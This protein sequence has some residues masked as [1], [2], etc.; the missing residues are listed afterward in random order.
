MKVTVLPVDARSTFSA[1]VRASVPEP[2]AALLTATVCVPETV[3]SVPPPVD[4]SWT[5]K[6]PFAALAADGAAA[7]PPALAEV[8]P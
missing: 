7:A 4:F 1:E 6:V 8:S 5:V 3:V 2:S